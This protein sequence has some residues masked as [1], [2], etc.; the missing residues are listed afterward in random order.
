MLIYGKEIRDRLKEEIRQEAM[1]NTMSMV[2]VRVGDDPSSLSYVRGISKFAEETGVKAEI[3]N[4]PEDA[5]ENE[6]IKC[7]RKLN[8]DT[9]LTGIMLQTPLPK[10]LDANRLVNLIDYN[11]DVEGIHN[12]NL[13]KLIS[14][15]EGVKP[16]TPK[17]VISMLKAYDIALEGKKVTI[18]GRSMTVGSPLAVMMTGENCTV[19]LCHSKTR[20]LQKEALNADILVAAIGKQEFVTPD[21][22]NE[23]T[24]IIDVGINFDAQG[25]MFGDVHSEASAKARMASAVP[26][27]V[28]MITVAELFDN[29]RVLSR[30]QAR[31]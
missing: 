2:I 11:K 13:G 31:F 4:L 24:V 30:N 18:I 21:M 19:T 15:E 25:K 9:G 20:D 16:A 28:G 27:G 26:G 1:K 14:K 6:V 7:I 23:D 10:H 17:A 12:Y 29:L 5:S 3:L 8:N 22:V